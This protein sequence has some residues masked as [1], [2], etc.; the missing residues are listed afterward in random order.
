[1]CVCATQ[2][3][4]GRAEMCRL[5]QILFVPVLLVF[6]VQYGTAQSGSKFILVFFAKS[7]FYT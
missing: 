6:S 5:T 3:Q 2:A 1:M 7:D 4:Q